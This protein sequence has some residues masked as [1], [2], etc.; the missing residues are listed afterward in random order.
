MDETSM[1][2]GW[3]VGRRIAGQR[4]TRVPVAFSIEWD[5]DTTGRVKFLSGFWYY[6]VSDLTPPASA[7]IGGRLEHIYYGSYIDHTIEASD[8]YVDHDAYWIGS[9]PQVIVVP[10]DN[11]TVMNGPT[12][13]E[14]GIYFYI[15]ISGSRTVK[16]STP[17]A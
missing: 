17:N 12:A 5:G 6:K 1:V 4:M 10:Y 9:T 16:L 2:L 14:K 3:L 15:G 11:A 7:L 13:P 8:I